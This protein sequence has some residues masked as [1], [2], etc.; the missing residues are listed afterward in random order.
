MVTINKKLQQIGE[1]TYACYVAGAGKPLVLLHGFTGSG[2]TWR[3]FM[4][5]WASEFKVIAI[6]LPGHGNTQTDHFPGMLECCD[7]LASLFDELNIQTCHLLG[8]SMGGRIALSFTMCHPNRV[9]SLL[10]E[11]TSPGLESIQERQQRRQW[12]QRLADKIVQNGVEAFVAEWEQIPLFASQYDLP[13]KTKANIQKERLAQSAD[14][15]SQS[16]IK[17]G[18]GTQP[19]WWGHLHLLNMPIIL[20]VGSLDRKFIHINKKMAEE[21][22]QSK[23]I[24]VDDA[25]H[26]VHV[27][28]PKKFATIVLGHLSPKDYDG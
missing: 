22:H 15:L 12:D 24:I 1:N 16:L 6:D 14:G 19:S 9:L 26:A 20:I 27:E 3:P 7:E 23:L 25:G 4:E 5:V 11:S 2:E 28:Q 8:Y 10:L 17:M 21:I 13:A 18:T